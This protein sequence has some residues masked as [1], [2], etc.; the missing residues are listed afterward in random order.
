MIDKGDL[1][2]FY[3]ARGA[4]YFGAPNVNVNL[5]IDVQRNTPNFLFLLTGGIF[6]FAGAITVPIAVF[7]KGKN[8]KPAPVQ[9]HTLRLSFLIPRVRY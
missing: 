2:Y 9:P 1:Y 6:L 4:G 3:V 5:N 8:G 7:Y